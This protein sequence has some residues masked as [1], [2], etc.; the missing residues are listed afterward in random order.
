EDT[1]GASIRFRVPEGASA[2]TDLVKGEIAVEHATVSDFII[3]RSDGR[4]T[5]N[6][7]VVVDDV[8]MKISHVIRG[9]GHISNTPRQLMLYRGVGVEPPA[10]AHIPMILGPD[11]KLLSKRHGATSLAEYRTGGYLPQALINYLSLLSWS[12]ES[13][14][15]FLPVDRLVREMDFDRLGKSAAVFDPEKLRWLNGKHL[16]ELVDETLA[17]LFAG[18]AGEKRKLFD[19]RQWYELTRACREKVELLTDIGGLL[20]N[21]TGEPVEI[22]DP[23]D[24]QLLGHPDAAKVLHEMSLR[25]EKLQ[26]TD[27]DSMQALLA[28]VSAAVSVKGK[29]LYMPLRLALTGRRHGP[30]LPR[31]MAVIGPERCA[32]LLSDALSLVQNLN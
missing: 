32:R 12:S 16:R 26:A 7:A 25:L 20:E 31:I 9:D 5:Y 6:F 22:T 19:R 29:L 1:A 10:F 2:W 13:G 15:E 11:H 24:R 27:V 30:E 23:E 17:E 28:G 18:F 8:E 4:P 21:F 3:L 14:E